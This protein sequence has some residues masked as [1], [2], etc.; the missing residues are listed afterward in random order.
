V[1]PE[2][3]AQ[4]AAEQQKV[5]IRQHTIIYELID[6][7]KLAMTGMLDPVFKEVIQGHAEVRE[8]F[9]I[10]KVG[11]VAGCYVADG[12]VRSNSQIRVKRDGE[13]IHTG[14]IEALKRFKNDVSEVKAGIECGISIANYNGVQVGDTLE[15][16]IMERVLPTLGS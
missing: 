16:F 4:A 14:R 12:A 15:A 13:V 2:R 7:V 5:D 6:E 9:K 10:S 8:T 11:V 1:K 3:G